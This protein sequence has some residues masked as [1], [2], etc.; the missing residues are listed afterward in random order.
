MDIDSK[1]ED[2]GKKWNRMAR[3]IPFLRDNGWIFM[4]I[5]YLGLIGIIVA[6][7][8]VI[9]ES[10]HNTYYNNGSVDGV[11]INS[12]F[13]TEKPSYI[14]FSSD[15]NEYVVISKLLD[16]KNFNLQVKKTNLQDLNNVSS[17]YSGNLEG[18][19]GSVGYFA[20]NDID[21]NKMRAISIS[22][23]GKH[24]MVSSDSGVSQSLSWESDDYR[25]SFIN[26]YLSNGIELESFCTYIVS[27]K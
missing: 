11:S 3:K 17:F 10:H 25:F 24:H 21:C 18:T 15:T 19:I 2:I 16:A 20:Y 14:K 6:I 9:N 5:F 13:N 1:M 12:D 7:Y 22:N 27:N 4:P 8:F 26:K 23:L